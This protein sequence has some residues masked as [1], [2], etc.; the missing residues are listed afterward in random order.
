MKRP[1]IITLICINAVLLGALVLGTAI[2]RATAQVPGGGVD[3][4]LLTGQMS[5]DYDAIYVLDL[6]QSRLL[7]FRFDR[8]KKTLI[9][10]RGRPLA[11]DFRVRGP[12]ERR[13][14]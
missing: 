3:Y 14:R 1:L 2:P 9:P 7:A 10:Y 8:T 12:A 6:A 5:A 13:P 11:E 4:L